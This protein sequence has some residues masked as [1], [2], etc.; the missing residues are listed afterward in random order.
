M[1]S[2]YRPR[3]R[4]DNLF[5]SVCLSVRFVCLSVGALMLENIIECASQNGW[6]FKVVV[7]STGCAIVVDHALN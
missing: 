1:A 5:G 2:N 3:S 4:G 6:A 7:V